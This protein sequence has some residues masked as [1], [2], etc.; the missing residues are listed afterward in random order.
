MYLYM[1]LIWQIAS[2]NVSVRDLIWSYRKGRGGSLLLITSQ[3][4]CE[5]WFV[6]LWLWMILILIFEM[7]SSLSFSY[8][9]AVDWIQSKEARWWLVVWQWQIVGHAVSRFHVFSVSWKSFTLVVRYKCNCEIRTFWHLLEYK[10]EIF[11]TK[12]WSKL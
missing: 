5:L 8:T 9:C 2:F 1:I 12:Y 6:T 10:N 4:D 11:S 7:R 3:H